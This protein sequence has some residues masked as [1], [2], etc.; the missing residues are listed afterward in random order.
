LSGQ[1]DV[2]VG[3]PFAGQQ[4]L[5]NSALVAHCVNTVPLRAELD[6]ELPFA[7]HL[8]AVG[9]QLAQAQEHSRLTFGSLVRRLQ[10]DRDP[11][12][13]PLVAT[14]FAIDKVGAPFDFG[15]VTVASVGTPRR[16]SNFE[17]QVNAVDN[18][19]DLVLECDYNADLF[20]AP[21]I[22]RWLAHYENLLRGIVSRPDELVGTLP[23]LGDDESVAMGKVGAASVIDSVGGCLHE[24]FEGRVRSGPG[25]VAAVC[26]EK[27]L[28]FVA[29]DRR[30]NGLA[31]RLRELGVGPD[32]LVGLRSERSLN[33]VVGVLGILKAGGAYVPLD[34]AYPRDRVRFMLEDSGVKVVVTE[35]AFA[36]DFGDV[37]ELVLVDREVDEA[38]AGPA[39]GVGPENLAYVMYT[40]GSTGRPKGVLISHRNVTRLFDATEG[41]FGFGED[42]VW[43]LFHSY[44]FDFSVWEM[45]GAL[46]YGGRLVVVP[47]WV[48]RSPEE[49]RELVVREGVTVLNQTPSAFR[50]FAA[51]DARAGAPVA[52]ALRYV[53]FGGEALELSSLRPWFDRH[54]DARPR[55]VNMYGI[56]ETT[57]HVTY[58]PIEIADLDAGAGS[59]IGV[60]ISDLR[61]LVLDAHGAPVPTGVAGELYVGGAGVARG[62][63]NRPELT[64]E[65]FVSDRSG[66]GAT[67]YRSG[68]RARRLENGELEYLGRID[69]QVKIRGFRIELGEIEALLGRYPDVSD[70]AVTVREDVANDKRLVAYVVAPRRPAGFA[71]S[72]KAHLEAELPQYMIPAQVITIE[73]L[74]LTPNGKLDRKALPAPDQAHQDSRPP[75]VAPRTPTERTLAEVWGN[76]LGIAD[77]GVTDNFFDSGGDSLKA[78]R[79]VTEVRAAF[80]VDAGMRHLFEHPTIAGLA[81]LVDVL[82]VSISGSPAGGDA[83]REEMEI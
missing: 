35:S 63:L 68:D 39:S 48:S 56:T 60:A 51:A 78:A 17:L 14:T 50:Q 2:V 61:V 11:S 32:V 26:G 58:R 40:S 7:V 77:P 19:S 5:E 76:A 31:W 71:D 18:G 57:V 41:W 9:R 44:A 67:L 16:Y 83:V 72:L 82:A 23:L 47:Y 6:P 30:A 53:I 20:T 22:R 43:S 55:L 28:S 3:I 64:A 52:S 74:P 29:L 59:V 49:F 69:D 46:L 45:W 10:I 36:P 75:Y 62:Y 13:T 38:V 25:R 8:R 4:G 27:S 70:A 79:M 34:P 37:V 65:R 80:G 15:D 66:S 33:V 73:H 81:E 42:D 24:R 54:G 21:T 1:T 12:R